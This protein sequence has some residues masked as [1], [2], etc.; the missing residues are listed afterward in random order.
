M[1]QDVQK[2]STNA[3]S[4][5][6]QK[7]TWDEYVQSQEYQDMLDAMEKAEKAFSDDRKELWNSMD[8]HQQVSL[9]SFIAIKLNHAGQNQV[10]YRTTLYTEFEFDEA[11][12]GAAQLSGLLTLHNNYDNRYDEIM[13]DY[14]NALTLFNIETTEEEILQ[15]H[16]AY[17]KL[18]AKAEKE[19][20]P[21]SGT[22]DEQEVWKQLNSDKK[23]LAFCHVVNVIEKSKRDNLG[24]IECFEQGFHLDEQIF[25][26]MPIFKEYYDMINNVKVKDYRIKNMQQGLKIFDLE[27]SEED[28]VLK[29]NL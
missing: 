15:K 18:N 6:A 16:R 3:D 22:V 25:N 17:L 19:Y 10:S 5:T 27:V 11:S 28:I 24:A 14:Q 9:L 29:M 1:A 20:Q 12:Y 21:Y 8:I 13:I 4:N 23:L 26:S 2:N 7:S